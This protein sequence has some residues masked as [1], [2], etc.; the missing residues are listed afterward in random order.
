ML[1]FH[2]EFSLFLFTQN[3]CPWKII[4]EQMV[5]NHL[6]KFMMRNNKQMT[7]I[8]SQMVFPILLS[9]SLP[10]FVHNSTASSFIQ[11]TV[12]VETLALTADK[13]AFL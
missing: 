7:I 1:Q 3:I 10:A 12:L 4:L 8:H 6:Y 11:I 13:M 5:L 2:F 9:E